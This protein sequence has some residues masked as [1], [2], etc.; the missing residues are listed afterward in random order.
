M[1]FN[2]NFGYSTT[3]WNNV[4]DE[5]VM[6]W[7][8]INKQEKLTITFTADDLRKKRYRCCIDRLSGDTEIMSIFHTG[9]G[10]CIKDNMSKMLL[11]EIG[12]A[13]MEVIRQKLKDMSKAKK[14]GT[15][16]IQA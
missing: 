8:K 16:S 2:K 13:E 1:L 10:I 6:Y 15:A 11:H 3:E 9:R 4:R 5:I 12:N 7:N 14:A